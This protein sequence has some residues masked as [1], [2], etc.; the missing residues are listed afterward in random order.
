MTKRADRASHIFSLPTTQAIAL[1]RQVFLASLCI[2]VATA[3]PGHAAQGQQNGG[4]PKPELPA[5]QQ[6]GAGKVLGLPTP[7]RDK[8]SREGALVIGTRRDQDGAL[9]VATLPKDGEL[10]LVGFIEALNSRKDLAD[11]ELVAEYSLL[12]ED[13]RRRI[14][15]RAHR[16]SER[17]VVR[18]ARVWRA[19]AERDGEL[20]LVTGL[21]S[22]SLGKDTVGVVDD[23]FFLLGADAK[24]VGLDALTNANR[25]LRDVI[26]QR[27]PTLL[28][29]EDL[30]RLR[31]LLDHKDQGARIAALEVLARFLVDKPGEDLA[32]LTACLR[33]T[34]GALR[35]QASTLLGEMGDRAVAPLQALVEAQT[36]GPEWFLATLLL[37]RR[38]VVVPDRLLS[39]K[40]LQRLGRSRYD[41]RILARTVATIVAGLR[42]FD[43]AT[44]L[45]DKTSGF[46][47]LAAG[48]IVAN[49]IQ[50]TDVSKYFPELGVCHD[51]ARL[52][53]RLLTG[54]DFGSD[55]KRWQRWWS[56]ASHD[57]VPLTVDA[58]F[59][60]AAAA[61][62]SLEVFDGEAV[63][64]VFLG[65]EAAEP[66]L[67]SGAF[68]ARLEATDFFDLVSKLRERGLFD[69]SARLS[70]A[71][72]I[73]EARAIVLATASGRSRDAFPR[74]ESLRFA[75]FERVLTEVI[76]R[77]AWQAFCPRDLEGVARRDW[78][79]EQR[80]RFAEAK[81]DAERRTHEI[82]L[83]LRV[84]PEPDLD[85]AILEQGIGRLFAELSRADAALPTRTSEVLLGFAGRK[86]LEP[87]LRE[88]VFAILARTKAETPVLLTAMRGLPNLE[89][90]ARLMDVL[91]ARGEDAL[92]AALKH[93]APEL[94]AS[95]ASEAARRG[96][97]RIRALLIA[98]LRDEDWDVRRRSAES[99][100]LLG[101]QAARTEVLRLVADPDAL[102]RHAALLA[103]A[104]I[105]GPGAFDVLLRATGPGQPGDRLAAARALSILDE[106]RA[107]STLVA[108]A[109]AHLEE[110][111]GLQALRGLEDRSNPGLR[112]EVRRWLESSDNPL[113]RRSFTFLL[114]EM[115]DAAVAPSLLAMLERGESATRACMLLAQLS[116]LDYCSRKERVGLYRTW[117]ESFAAESL[118]RRLIQAFTEAGIPNRL[119]G[120]LAN[121]TSRTELV[122]ELGRIVIEASD[123]QWAARALAGHAL[124]EFT[125][126]DFGAVRRE[127][128]VTERRGL[129]ERYRAAV[130][131]ASND[132]R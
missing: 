4:V 66:K 58:G 78:W 95:A 126:K 118:G 49:L 45:R 12:T 80:R 71:K 32:S 17:A 56:E 38:E 47:D 16:L 115:G 31:M 43:D 25:V 122:D 91:S 94:R 61:K 19:R 6:A 54:M 1:A 5:G 124:R 55:N 90:R 34:D 48:D 104:R 123:E 84:L 119:E 35:A 82:E 20:G 33:H 97:P 44:T 92:V 15:A 117:I 87:Q 30:P 86:E 13:E 130:L 40:A 41:G 36:D 23:A 2:G 21:K 113:L 59:D 83:A 27:L 132:G 110:P 98:G 96:S 79:R 77:E 100:G 102:V 11:A 22:R 112:A 88:R 127:M 46:S 108:I 131:A 9:E 8:A 74:H 99:L 63:A 81:S 64:S 60:A 114:A 105:G 111:L 51:A 70:E 26:V 67:V 121:S 73:V 128:R 93:D 107:A 72:T 57:F 52:A 42:L 53:L 75:T 29:N 65:P 68:V 50:V 76:D 129:V 89:L 69:V 7:A 85:P 24:L 18:L 37:A 39:E 101:D 116:G 14:I 106:P 10:A 120:I 3:R 125:G 109:A 28:G 103:I 62:S